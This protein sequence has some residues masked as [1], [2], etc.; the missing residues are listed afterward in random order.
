MS[1]LDP[2]LDAKRSETRR[3][4]VITGAGG[5]RRWSDEEKARAVK[6]FAPARSSRRLRVDTARHRSSSSRGDERRSEKPR[7]FHRPSCRRSWKPRRGRTHADECTEG[8]DVSWAVMEIE[9]ATR[10]FGS[11]AMRTSSRR[12]RSFARCRPR[13]ASDDRS[14]GAF[15]VMVASRPVDFR[16]RGGRAVLVRETMRAPFAAQ[17][18]SFAPS[19]RIGSS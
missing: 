15:R 7:R 9:I 19:A 3:I 13:R 17:F 6:S 18:M 16:R 11:G 12:R 14:S 1:R 2:T 10:I 5:R 4:E 8:G